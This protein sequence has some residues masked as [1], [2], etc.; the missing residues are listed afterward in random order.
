[1]KSCGIN[2]AIKPFTDNNISAS[3]KRKSENPRRLR[4]IA[5]DHQLCRDGNTTVVYVPIVILMISSQSIFLLFSMGIIQTPMLRL[6]FNNSIN[7]CYCANNCRKPC[8][9]YNLLSLLQSLIR[10]FVERHLGF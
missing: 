7:T 8:V 4:K 5:L 3:F 2:H 9:H 10:S 6:Q 1:M